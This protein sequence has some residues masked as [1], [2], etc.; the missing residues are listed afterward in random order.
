MSVTLDIPEPENAVRGTSPTDVRRLGGARRSVPGPHRYL[1]ARDMRVLLEVGK[2]ASNAIDR[3][4]AAAEILDLLRRVTPYAAAT[5]VTWNPLSD[6]HQPLANVGYPEEII[7]RVDGLHREDGVPDLIHDVGSPPIRWRDLPFDFRRVAVVSELFIPVGLVDGVATILT[8][9]ERRTTG[10]LCINTDTRRHPDDAAMEAL[11]ILQPI[12]AGFA[13]YLRTPSFVVAA[14]DPAFAAA[15]VT[16]SGTV[17]ALAGRQPGAYLRLRS[18]LVEL[19]A[20]MLRADR[21]IPR[22]LWR[23]HTRGWHR[24]RMERIENGAL[25]AE[26][27]SSAPYEL[28][29]RE[30]D[31]L[32]LLAGGASNPEIAGSLF[33]TTKTVAKHVEHVLE[34]LGCASRTAA[35]ARAAAEGVLRVPVGEQG[36]KAA[37]GP[38]MGRHVPRAA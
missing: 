29:D 37:S 7:S 26:C 6:F 4:G 10:S 28:T 34:K 22:W 36:S 8:T 24:V 15:I 12:L 31:V 5:L 23:D 3:A 33:V 20:A 2:V 11:V 27:P 32:T 21:L 18:P 13:D 14:L 9:A 19:A 25:V 38:V 1:T 35:A 17:V 30:L 16:A